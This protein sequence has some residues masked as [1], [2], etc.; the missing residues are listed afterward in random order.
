MTG[1]SVERWQDACLAAAMLA[2]APRRL[3]GLWLIAR[4]GPVRDRWLEGVEA[5]LAPRRIP[6]GAGPEHLRGGIDLTATL[7]S[8]R[9]V[10][11]RGLL[12]GDG[13]LLLPMAERIDRGA[14]ALIG[15]AIDHGK[16]AVAIDERAVEGEALPPSLADR[17]GLV[18]PLEGLAMADCLAPM[19]GPE[20]LSDLADWTGTGFPDRLRMDLAATAAAFG[21]GIRAGMQADCA[22]RLAAAI[23][24]ASEVAAEDLATAL[25]LVIAPR[26]TCLPESGEEPAPPPEQENEQPQDHTDPSDQQKGEAQ[27][28][29]ED[30]LVEATRA[31]IPP[32]LLAHLMHGFQRVQGRGGQGAERQGALRGRPAGIRPGLPGG[33]RRLDLSATLT[34]AAPWQKLRLRRPG[35]PLEVRGSDLRLRRF[36]ERA[37]TLTIFAV[38]ASGSAAMARLAEAKGAVETLLAE[39]YR[40]R[41]QVALIA[42]RGERAELILPPTRALARAKR[43]LGG[44]PGGGG[45]PLAAGIAAALDLAMAGRRRGQTVAL[46]LLTDGKGNIPLDP[47]APRQTALSDAEQMAR[48][49]RAADLPCLFVDTSRRPRSEAAALAAEMGARY[50]PMPQA[51]PAQIAAAAAATAR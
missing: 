40:R 11:A 37:E 15:H 4:P 21:T 25:R 27:Q 1:A 6:P 45:T 51:D 7:A 28:P 3:G 36:R 43:T 14:A 19:P 49:I 31:A 29:P 22:A 39:A 9:P 41:D 26:A 23:R 5:L 16:A 13:A 10:M 33:G 24:G 50:L 20:D 2:L 17:L 46:I 47:E 32:A 30:M 8:G 12:E 42:F 34:T 18:V 38:D 44:L 48:A 35:R